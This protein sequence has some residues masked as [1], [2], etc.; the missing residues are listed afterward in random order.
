MCGSTWRIGISAASGIGWLMFLVY[1][2][3]FLAD[4]YSL[5]QNI[6]IFILSVLALA[7]VNALAWL[8]FGLKQGRKHAG[9]D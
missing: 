1:W 4:G 6:G 2:L 7:L 9:K 3:F 8:P 5:Y